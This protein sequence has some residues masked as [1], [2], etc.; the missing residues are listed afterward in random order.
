LRVKLVD[1][2]QIRRDGLQNLVGAGEDSVAWLAFKA[3]VRAP[4]TLEV[5]RFSSVLKKST[6]RL[7]AFWKKPNAPE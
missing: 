6:P 4:A 3:S 2:F 7:L 1:V 5:P